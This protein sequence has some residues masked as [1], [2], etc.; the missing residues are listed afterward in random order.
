MFGPV[1]AACMNAGLDWRQFELWELGWMLDPPKVAQ[2]RD[3]VAERDAAR[4]AGE[5]P[6]PLVVEA[7]QVGDRDEMLASL[8]ALEAKRAERAAQQER[9]AG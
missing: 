9:E 6:P 5:E 2:S 1:A 3:V 4:W 8:S 7:D